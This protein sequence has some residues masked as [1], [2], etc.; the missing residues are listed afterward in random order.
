MEPD[1]VRAKRKTSQATDW[2]G[3]VTV[4]LGD[5]TVTF[6]H[7]L[8]TEGEFLRLQQVIDTDTLSDAASDDAGIEPETG[9]TEAQQ[10][11][12]EL[13]QQSELTDDEQAELREL[14]EEVASQ[15]GQIK[16]ALGSEGFEL[17]MEFGQKVIKPDA[18]SVQYV[19]DQV[20]EDPQEAMTLLGMDSLPQHLSKADVRE[21]LEDELESM[22]TNQPYPIKL[23]V[24]LQAMSET[25]SVLGNGL[26]E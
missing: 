23:N 12:L 11:L 19:Y 21:R 7:R 10:R 4:S 26:R 14:T 1:F 17:L 22:I 13:Q 15:T 9:E 2:R 5:E 6:K 8:L 18:D 24:G 16:E 3:D 20:S 25:I